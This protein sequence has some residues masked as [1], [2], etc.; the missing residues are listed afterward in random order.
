MNVNFNCS[1]HCSIGLVHFSD[2]AFLLH[3][4]LVSYFEADGVKCRK[5]DSVAGMSK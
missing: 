3:Y 2:P 1:I 4:D 5:L